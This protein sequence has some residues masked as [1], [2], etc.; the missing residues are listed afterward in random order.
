MLP[1]I[2]P[3]FNNGKPPSNSSFKTPYNARTNFTVEGKRLH[4]TLHEQK[5]KLRQYYKYREKFVLGHQYNLK[6]LNMINGVEKS[7]DFLEVD[8]GNNKL[9]RIRWISMAYLLT[10]WLILMLIIQGK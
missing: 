5:R 7:E 3:P 2:S 1:K 8:E 10:H 9:K 6:N 4:G